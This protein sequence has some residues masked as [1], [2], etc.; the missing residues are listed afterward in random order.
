MISVHFQGIPFNITVIQVCAPMTDD[1]EV[2]LWRPKRPPRTNSKERCPFHRRGLECESWTSR[3]TWNNRQVWPWHTQWSMAKANRVLSR[4]HTGHSKQ[5]FPT[6]QEIT[7][8]MDKMVNIEIWLIIFFA[9][10]DG[11]ALYSQQ[12]QDL[13]LTVAQIMGSLLQNSDLNWRK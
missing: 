6:T 10:K 9:L 4:E 3:D 2:V 13:E 7:L 11:E 1:E 12:Q 8:C 5:P